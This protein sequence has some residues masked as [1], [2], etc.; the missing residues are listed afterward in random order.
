MKFSVENLHF[1]QKVRSTTPKSNNFAKIGFFSFFS[2]IQCP[3]PF[4]RYTKEEVTIKVDACDDAAVKK[5]KKNK[6]REVVISPS[7]SPDG[8]KQRVETLEDLDRL[9]DPD[10]PQQDVVPEDDEAGKQTP[11]AKSSVNMTKGLLVQCYRTIELFGERTS[12][13]TSL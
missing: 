6:T 5:R 10:R 3:W 4:S 11:A 13:T 2:S 8:K 7:L 9:G 12:D 1:F